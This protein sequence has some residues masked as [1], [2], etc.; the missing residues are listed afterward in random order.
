MTACECKHQEP[1]I[2][3]TVI[4]KIIHDDFDN[5]KENLIMMMQAI[6]K[7]YRYL[8]YSALRYLSDCLTIPV[9]KIYEIATFYASF[10]LEPKGKHIISVC[11]GTACHLKGSGEMVKYISEATGLAPGKTT[12]DMKLTLEAVNCVGACGLA[13]VVI[14]NDKYNPEAELSL[15][16]DFIERVKAE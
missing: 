5:N 14:I 13:P 12:A 8:P 11:T 1:V 4:D 3:F 2:D 6:Q 15:I 10:S 9:T 16:S 7:E